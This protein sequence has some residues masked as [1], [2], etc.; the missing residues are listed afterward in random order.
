MQRFS[1][2]QLYLQQ[3]TTEDAYF[4]ENFGMNSVWFFTHQN[5]GIDTEI[6]M[7]PYVVAEILSKTIFS[8]MAGLII[9][10]RTQNICVIYTK[11]A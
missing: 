4:A 2:L 11:M 3:K 7:I 5:I 10:I 9:H 6:I 1:I 8:V